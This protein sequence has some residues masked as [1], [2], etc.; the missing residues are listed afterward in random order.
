MEPRDLMCE[1][2]ERRNAQWCVDEATEKINFHAS[3]QEGRSGERCP[4]L[5]V[6]P[7]IMAH[8]NPPVCRVIHGFE[9]ICAESLETKEP[10]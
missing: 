2:G 6:M 1:G 8:N 9:D 5:R 10:R 4:A 3:G 7:V